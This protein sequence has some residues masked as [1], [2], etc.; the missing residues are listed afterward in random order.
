MMAS[1]KLR[2]RKK[3]V[4]HHKYGMENWV[5][6]QQEHNVSMA[7]VGTTPPE[8]S[9]NPSQG[10]NLN[11]KLPT[12][13]N[14]L[15]QQNPTNQHYFIV[16]PPNQD[17]YLN[18]V[19]TN[20]QLSAS[21]AWQALPKCH[22]DMFNGDASLFYPW[23]TAFKA[24]LQDAEVSPK[25]EINYLRQY[26]QEVWKLIDSY[27]KR[28]HNNAS[29]LL[30][31]LWGE[32]EKRLGNTAIIASTLMKGLLKTANFGEK[33]SKK[34]KVFADACSEVYNQLESLPGLACMN[35]PSAMR[36]ILEKL[37]SSLRSKWEKV[38]SYAEEHNNAYPGFHH[39]TMIV[40]K[41]AM[42]QNHPN[43]LAS[44]AIVPKKNINTKR[45][46]SSLHLTSLTMQL[47]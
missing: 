24:M 7:N 37:L 34:L 27:C 44:Y 41:Q 40:R 2:M 25:Q 29:I 43:I 4:I 20:K 45:K 46:E 38:A 18:T 28:Q 19:V 16:S 32:L 33:G 23:K 1:L 15:I 11:Q 35:Y 10:L 36:P 30:H 9:G 14:K 5:L 13:T 31:Q 6:S 12:L 17:E 3:E 42:L 26:T 47:Y 39:F 22:P 21:L 8:V